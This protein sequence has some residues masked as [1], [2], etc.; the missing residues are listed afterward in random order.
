MIAETSFINSHANINQ[1][2][3]EAI[4]RLYSVVNDIPKYKTNLDALIVHFSVDDMLYLMN[5]IDRDAD[6][7]ASIYYGTYNKYFDEIEDLI[8]KFMYW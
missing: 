8:Y 3:H 4:D 1:L 5:A 2:K 6:F 7:K